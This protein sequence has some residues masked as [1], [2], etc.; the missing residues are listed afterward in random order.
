MSETERP[1]SKKEILIREG[2]RVLG[3]SGAGLMLI[4]LGV[5]SASG[6][7]KDREL[8]NAGGI[9]AVTGYA[10]LCAGVLY[11]GFIGPMNN[12]K[13]SGNNSPNV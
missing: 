13:G 2:H 7:M 4:G 11:E 10:L 9:I 1:K 5:L 8:F 6:V 12:T 3:A